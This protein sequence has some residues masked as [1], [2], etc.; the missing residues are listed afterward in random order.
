MTEGE[1]RQEKPYKKWR[2][3][4]MTALATMKQRYMC[5]AIAWITKHIHDNG[6]IIPRYIMMPCD[7]FDRKRV[8]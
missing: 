8:P 4:V 1:Q 6:A 2:F 3:F 5:F 7:P